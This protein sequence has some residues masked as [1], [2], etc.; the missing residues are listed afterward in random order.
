MNGG[1]HQN[2]PGFTR[3]KTIYLTARFHPL[4][5]LPSTFVL[6]MINRLDTGVTRLWFVLL[7]HMHIAHV[8]WFNIYFL[9]KLQLCRCFGKMVDAVVR[10]C[11]LY[12]LHK[13][14]GRWCLSHLCLFNCSLE[15][16]G[17]AMK[18][19]LIHDRIAVVLLVFFCRNAHSTIWIKNVR[20]QGPAA[21]IAGTK[22]LATLTKYYFYDATLARTKN[23]VVSYTR[24]IS[25]PANEIQQQYL[26]WVHPT[27]A[28]GE[29]DGWVLQNYAIHS[30]Y[31]N[32]RF[33]VSAF[34]CS[35]FRTSVRSMPLQPFKRMPFMKPISTCSLWTIS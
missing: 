17:A 11:T 30:T 20:S 5:L 25:S 10:K 2:F 19:M 22:C 29:M 18:K 31:F 21:A 14:I 33:S 3:W 13:W 27:I 34:S 4:P 16:W 35:W 26:E 12:S 24:S 15:L 8:A 28:G 1:T 7:V 9:K 23:M 32:N 6:D